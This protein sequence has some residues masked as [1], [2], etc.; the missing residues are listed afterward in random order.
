MFETC[1]QEGSNKGTYSEFELMTYIS[2]DFL[3]FRSYSVDGRQS[4]KHGQ[5]GTVL[6]LA[7][8]EDFH[9]P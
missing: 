7:R 9:R 1:D 8:I 6:L 4:G 5:E 3:R 2:V